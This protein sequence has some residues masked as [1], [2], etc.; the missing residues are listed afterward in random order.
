MYSFDDE[1]YILTEKTMAFLK[2]YFERCKTEANTHEVTIVMYSRLY[3]PY[4]ESL[5]QFA[6]FATEYFGY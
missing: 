2:S 6:A 5:P 3:Y 1:G 4:V